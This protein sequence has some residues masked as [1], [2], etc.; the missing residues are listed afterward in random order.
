[1]TLGNGSIGRRIHLGFG[2][3]L[4]LVAAQLGVALLGLERIDALRTHIVEDVDPPSRAAEDLERGVLQRAVAVRNLIRTGD[5]QYRFE[6]EGL[7]ADAQVEL[8]ELTAMPIGPEDRVAL[9]AVSAGFGNHVEHTAAL[10]AVFDRG[11]KAAELA[12]TEGRLA[13]ARAALIS[14]LRAFAELQRQHQ[15]DAQERTAALRGNLSGVFLV[16]ALLVAAALALTAILTT[17]AVRRPALVL[18]AAARAV[19]EGDLG[20]ALALA[21]VAGSRPTEFRAVG[22]AIARMAD[23]LRRREARAAAS[24]RLSAGLAGSLDPQTTATTALDQIVSYTGADVAAVYLAEDDALRRVAGRA[25]AGTPETLPRVGLVAEV[26]DRG[27]AAVLPDVPADLRFELHTG[28]GAVRPRTVIAVPLASRGESIGILLLGGVRPLDAEAA[29][30][31]ESAGGPLGIALHNAMSHVR[32]GKFAAELRDRNDQLQAQ[33]EELQA[34]GEEIQA[35]SEE[36]HAQGDEIRRH[37]E[38][39]AAAK[40][41]LAT[42]AAALEEVDRRKNEFL[43]TLGHELR[44][45]LSAISTAGTLLGSERAEEAVARHVG[46]IARQAR[47]LRRLVDDLLDLSRINHGKVELRRERVEL[48]AAIEETIH[49]VRPEAHARGQRISFRRHDAEVP[50]DA[51]PVRLEQV[52]SNLLRNALKYT[53][54]D[55]AITVAAEVDGREAIVRVGD[56]GIGIAPDLLPRIFEPFIQGAHSAAGEPGLGL[57]LALVRRL[58]EMHGGT[59][60]A[61]SRGAAAGTVFVV[62]LPLSARLPDALAPVED[63]VASPAEQGSATEP[64]VGAGSRGQILLVEDDP[65]V[66]ATTADALELCGFTVRVEGDA[67]AGLRACLETRPRVALLDI[68]LPGRSGYELARD[69]RAQLS[70]E[71]GLVAVTGYG[72]PGDR[73]RAV[74]AGFDEHLVKPVGVD[75]LCAAIERVAAL[76]VESS[77]A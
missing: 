16:A 31:A 11:A 39:L 61:E 69:I 43:A 15:A 58:V 17:R 57:G 59:V 30:F 24:A 27:R 21:P 28:F 63:G 77:A 35:Q 13:S 46:V 72:Q 40:D 50:V 38:E 66:A 34:Q 1:M 49:G 5:P 51:D 56:T 44:N 60:G 4:A 62:R 73:A 10:L 26:L 23:A 7:L 18:A 36:L 42:K 70:G 19:E 2:V 55:G 71:V 9:Q 68:G 54:D 37:N 25:A 32:I 20:P 48:G 6:Y 22:A 75:E 76:G 8:A 14:R 74:E 3:V 29:A 65:D 12:A 52:I 33:N 45:P 47:N 67:E 64:T 41:S 53:P